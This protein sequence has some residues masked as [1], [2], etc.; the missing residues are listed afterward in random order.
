MAGQTSAILKGFDYQHLLS[1]YHILSLKKDKTVTTIKLENTAAGQVDDLTLYKIDGS[2]DFYQVKYHVSAGNYSMDTLLTNDDGTTSLMEKFWKTWNILVKSYSRDK[3]RLILYSNWVQH[4]DDKILACINGENGR[5]SQLFHSAGARSDCGKKRKEWKVKHN[6]TDRDFID[7]TNSISFLL[8]RNFTDE[9]K[10][11]ISERMELLGLKND[12]NALLVSIGIVKDWIKDKTEDIT[13]NMLE[14]KLNSH[15]LYKPK[16]SEKSAAIHLVSVKSKQFDLNPDYILDWQNY[17][18]KVGGKGGHELIDND[19]WN[20]KMLPELVDLEKRVNS[21]TG[22]TLIKARGLARLSAWFGFG[23]TFSQV[24]GYKIEINQQDKLWRTD[25]TPNPLFK[26]ISE[27]GNGEA[28]GSANNT[29]AVGLS[30]SGSLEND[31]R[32][33][34]GQNG[35][36]DAL[37]LLRPERDLGP[38]CFQTA[39]DVTAFVHQAK[40]RIREFV[41]NNKAKKVLL[42]YFGPLSGACFLGHQLNAVCNEIQIMENIPG[43]YTTS[44][45]L[46]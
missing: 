33:Y 15:D 18:H 44:F 30:V 1:W 40:E 46:I 14:D 3:I 16:D 43:G 2:V 11:I 39:N 13:V 32:N 23:F 41:K 24:A 37:L 34:I 19:D 10:Q 38:G 17:F 27:N 28:L 36:I 4:S 6:A 5:L 12:T 20:K 42:F 35:A 9:L 22:V 45:T 21:E 25:E 31:V 26:I 29:V 8:G 7:F